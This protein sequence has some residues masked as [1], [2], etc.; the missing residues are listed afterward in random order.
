MSNQGHNQVSVS[1]W[2][3]LTGFSVCNDSSCRGGVLA[4]LSY[5][6]NNC[7]Q[8]SVAQEKLKSFSINSALQMLHIRRMGICSSSPPRDP[9]RGKG[10]RVFATSAHVR[11]QKALGALQGRFTEQT[12]DS[13]HNFHSHM[14]TKCKK[15]INGIQFI[16]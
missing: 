4:R 1:E 8:Y 2:N 16:T 10:V 7:H 9:G 3:E 15:N 12:W 14:H 11:G 13:V 5:F 6:C